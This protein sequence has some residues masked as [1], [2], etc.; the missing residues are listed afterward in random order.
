MA[1]HLNFHQLLTLLQSSFGLSESEGALTI[2]IDV[3]TNSLPD[4]P[5]WKDRRRIAADWFTIFQ[6]NVHRLPFTAI[7]CCV[8]DNVGSNN[9]D[10]PETVLLV[11]TATRKSPTAGESH[12][13]PLAEILSTSSIVLAITELSATAPLKVLARKYK[14]RGATLPGFSRKMVPALGLDYEKV[15]DRVMQIK[16]RMDRA[17]GA[18][19]DFR[20]GGTAYQLFC[21]LRFRGGH[22]SG[23]IIREPGTVANLPSGEAYIVPD[24]GEKPG[25]P[26]RTTGLLPVQFEKEVVVFGIEANRATM[27]LTKGEESDRQRL[28]LKNEPAYGNIAELGIGVLDEWGVRAVG[29]TLLD[30]KI[31]LHV[32]FGRSEHF[33][34]MTGPSSFNSPRNVVHVDW[35]YV[36][37]VQPMVSSE[38]VEFEYEDGTS[39]QVLFEGKIMI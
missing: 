11:D 17:V 22:A 32:A 24:E 10:L 8:Y 28:K 15:N 16:E 1:H 2:L 37:S 20:A 38:S 18:T 7:H 4:N 27:V 19:L 12:P 21:D 9:N 5:A 14:F 26:S 39:E 6:T 33:G 23:G 29:S 35:V 25:E 36:P 34:G 13:V 31:G 3:P 30:E